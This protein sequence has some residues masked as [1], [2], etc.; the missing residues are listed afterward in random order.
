MYCPFCRGEGTRVVDKRDNNDTNVTRRR[1]E[2]LNCAKRFTT[3]E[4]VETISLNV[5]K[6]SEKIEEFDRE[7]LKRGIRRAIKKREIPESEIDEMIDDIE[8][9]LLNRK[10]Q[11]VKSTDIGNMVLTRLKKIDKIGYLLYASVYRDFDSI[12]KFQDAIDELA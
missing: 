12:E 6:R 2:C 4:R 5:I 1:R 3:Y 8:L 11:K 7:K 9:K 10:S